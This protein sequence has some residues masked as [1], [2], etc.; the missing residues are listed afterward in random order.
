M[1]CVPAQGE[2]RRACRWAI[3]R[4]RILPA[5]QVFPVLRGVLIL[6]ILAIVVLVNGCA[7]APMGRGPDPEAYNL[8]TGYPAVG[9]QRWLGW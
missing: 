6:G 8:V 7:S 2:V 3:I 9:G 5:L 1:G 4:N